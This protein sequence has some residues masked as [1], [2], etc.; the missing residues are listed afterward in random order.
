MSDY[1]PQ[2]D[3]CGSL[4]VGLACRAW[5]SGFCSLVLE[6]W[7]DPPLFWAGVGLES[8]YCS[9]EA[10]SSLEVAVKKASSEESRVT[11]PPPMVNIDRGRGGGSLVSGRG[12]KRGKL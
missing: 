3:A 4:G 12:E 6:G 1:I 9:S 10:P 2:M 7:G 11:E 8:G 5:L